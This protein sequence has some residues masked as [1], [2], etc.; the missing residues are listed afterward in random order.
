[1]EK[2]RLFN[3]ACSL[4]CIVFRTAILLHEINHYCELSI[5]HVNVWNPDLMMLLYVVTQV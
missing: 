5:L 3:T 1:M 2:K 4:F